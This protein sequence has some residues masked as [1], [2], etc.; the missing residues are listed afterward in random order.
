[1]FLLK[2]GL[3]GMQMAWTWIVWFCGASIIFFVHTP[4]A[5]QKSLKP[6]PRVQG[7]GDETTN[8]KAII[9]LPGHKTEVFIPLSLSIPCSPR[10]QGLRLC[11]QSR[12]T[13]D[14]G[15]WVFL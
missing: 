1:M 5:A 8:P 6:K 4:P 2:S 14:I 13:V 3:D 11:L 9:L 10:N 7:P 12:A 15:D